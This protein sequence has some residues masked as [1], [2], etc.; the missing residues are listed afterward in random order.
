VLGY[1][2]AEALTCNVNDLEL[3]L[4][5]RIDLLKQIFGSSEK[6]DSLPPRRPMTAERFRAIASAH[7]RAKGDNRDG[8]G[9]AGGSGRS[10]GRGSG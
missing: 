7:N 9:S 8:R 5:A 1:T 6:P 4:R 10:A 3:A 2:P